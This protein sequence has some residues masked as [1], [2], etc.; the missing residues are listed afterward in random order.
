MNSDYCLEACSIGKAASNIFLELNNSV[1]DAAID[2]DCF[3]ENCF[4][5][6]PFKY[7]HIEPKKEY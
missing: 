7:K 2:F 3:V 4:K 6:C 5:E 1:S